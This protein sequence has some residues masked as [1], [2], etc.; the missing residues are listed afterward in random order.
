MRADQTTHER[1]DH[2][3]SSSDDEMRTLRQWS[4]LTSIPY[5]TLRSAVR[6]GSL[7]AFQ[8]TKRGSIFVKKAAIDQFINDAQ[9]RAVHDD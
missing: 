1:M 9:T 7:P 2:V 8:F 5:G 4:L 6:D 3:E